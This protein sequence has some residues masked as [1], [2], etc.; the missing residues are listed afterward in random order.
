ME[1]HYIPRIIVKIVPAE[2]ADEIVEEIS[3]RGRQTGFI[4]FD[5]EYNSTINNGINMIQLALPLDKAFLDEIEF[6]E[7]CVNLR[8]PGLR[9]AIVYIFDVYE[10]IQLMLKLDKLL[11]DPKIIKIGCG[12]DS[13]QRRLD[14][15]NLR[16]TPTIDIQHIAH[17]LGFQKTS[18]A[19]LSETLCG[20]SKLKAS[21]SQVKFIQRDPKFLDYAAYDGYLTM[22][23]YLKLIRYDHYKR[24]NRSL[25]GPSIEQINQF[26]DWLNKN[27]FYERSPQESVG[28]PIGKILTMTANSYS[29][30][31]SGYSRDEA[32]ELVGKMLQKLVALD[33]ISISNGVVFVIDRGLDEKSAPK[34][35]GETNYHRRAQDDR[36]SHENGPLS[37]PYIGGQTGDNTRLWG[38]R[39][40]SSLVPMASVVPVETTGFV[41]KKPVMNSQ[42]FVSPLL[43]LKLSPKEI[44]HMTATDAIIAYSRTKIAGLD[45]GLR[46]DSYIRCLINNNWQNLSGEQRRELA[47]A[48]VNKLI[49]IGILT[50]KDGI[51]RE[52]KQ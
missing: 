35:T 26:W 38:A 34:E 9:D 15:Y 52:K 33:Y 10:D 12:L 41:Q 1:G 19:H 43:G 6:D 47:Y 45:V 21:F 46:I 42:P 3:S 8:Q 29:A 25:K 49:E 32:G 16:V 39:P 30:L 4:A 17:T 27:V 28:I 13:D 51:I 14:Y 50:S 22:E 18:L 23:C 44:P 7:N 5:T 48:A 24:D 36:Y 2:Y 20:L 11:S 31:K 37:A 40:S